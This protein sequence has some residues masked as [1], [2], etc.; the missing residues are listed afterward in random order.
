MKKSFNVAAAIAAAGA[1]ILGVTAATTASAAVKEVT[2]AYQGPLTGDAAQTG[3]DE[4]NA[5]KYAIKKYNAT[6]PAVKVNLVAIDDQGA[7]AVALTVAPGAAANKKII[8]IVGPAFSGATIASLPYYKA[9]RLPMISPSATNVTLTNPKSVNY[10]YP[11]FHRV[12]ST[13]AFQGPA[14][15]VWAVQNQKSPKV[16]IVDDKSPYGTGLAAFTKKGLAA[17]TWAG[18]DS[19]PDDTKDFSATIIKIKASGTNV[20]I[21]TGYYSQAAILIKQLR[22]AGYTGDY[23]AGDGVLSQSFIDN[24]GKDAEGA[25]MVAPTI[26]LAVGNPEM[27]ADYV[28]LMGEASGEYSGETITITN[29]FLE[30]IKAGKLTR[31]AMLNW[32]NGY[33][34]TTFAGTKLSFDRNGDNNGA[35]A[36][37]GFIV[38]SGK[39]VAVKAVKW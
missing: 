2:I 29:V 35:A 25:L 37:G 9:G 30:G 1:L 24:A 31:S 11:V 27:E 21:Y 34:G 5:V 15:A 17:G 14:L 8:A 13:D 26:P 7:G 32:I 3:I 20:V 23:A 4:L 28:K 19:T 38:K 16:Y 33:H 36:I 12:P 22:T 6:N 39:N 18:S 10:G